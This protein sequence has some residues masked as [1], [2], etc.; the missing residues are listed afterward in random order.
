VDGDAVEPDLGERPVPGA[1]LRLLHEVEDLEAVDD[2]GEDGVVAVEVRLLGVGDEEL[3]AVG[4]GPVVGHRHDPPCVVLHHPAKQ[5]FVSSSDTEQ[6]AER[7]NQI[8]NRKEDQP[9]LRDSL[10]SSANL[11]PQMEEPPLPEP[12]GSPPWIMKPLMFRW[13]TV[14][15]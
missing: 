3:A 7:P 9:T 13:N 12:V 5:K 10:N 8:I 11:V 1:G 2:L 6:R 15:S 4:V 14:P